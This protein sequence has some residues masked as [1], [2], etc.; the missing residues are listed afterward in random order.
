M[1]FS[2]W[3]HV[4]Q[5]PAVLREEVAWAGNHLQLA[6]LFWLPAE[7]KCFS[8]L[9]EEEVKPGC[10][11]ND[12]EPGAECGNTA[13]IA[14]HYPSNANQEVAARISQECRSSGKFVGIL[15]QA[16]KLVSRCRPGFTGSMPSHGRGV[17]QYC[18]NVAAARTEEPA[19]SWGEI[20]G[21]SFCSWSWK[22]FSILWTDTFSVEIVNGNA[23]RIT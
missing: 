10:S 23:K 21:P 5:R 20:S 3:S 16:K 6:T 14:T 13:S 15:A 17:D 2:C 8:Y 19:L 7:G 1:C 22:P 9:C 11:L 4:E 12:R 18:C